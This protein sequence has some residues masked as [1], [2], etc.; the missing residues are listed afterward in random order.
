MKLI[1]T[2]Q[3]D[4]LIEIIF[5]FA[6][7]STIIGFSFTGVIS[8][9][10]NAVSAQQRTQALEMAQY[11][12]E[13]LQTYRNSLPWDTAGNVCPS[14]IGG[15]SGGCS[16]TPSGLAT[17]DL[18]NSSKTYCMLSVES[19]PGGSTRWKLSDNALDCDIVTPFLH[20][21]PNA[22]TTIKFKPTG[23]LVG[24]GSISPADTQTIQADV[25]VEWLG[26]FG[27]TES[28]SN[29][30]ILTRQK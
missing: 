11:Q 24:D 15:T 7:L 21:E 17:I 19:I 23:R 1:N 28:V 29:I 8:A 6:I 18:A 2:R 4:T 12:S 26:Q 14:F 25:R 22:V 13:A 3:G 16:P 9:R 27:V 5:A 20:N 10:R 30:V